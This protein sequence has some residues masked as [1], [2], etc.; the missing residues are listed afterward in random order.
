MLRA[1]TICFF[2]STHFSLTSLPPVISSTI[3]S[4]HSC[5]IWSPHNCHSDIQPPSHRS[6]LHSPVI[7]SPASL[8]ITKSSTCLPLP[9]LYHCLS[10][11]MISY[12]FPLTH[13]HSCVRA[14]SILPS[15]TGTQFFIPIAHFL[16]AIL[17]ATIHCSSIP[18]H[19]H[20]SLCHSIF[21]VPVT[22]VLPATVTLSSPTP[23][24]SLFPA[25]L[26]TTQ[27]SMA[28]VLHFPWNAKSLQ[29]P[30]PLPSL[31]R[32]PLDHSLSLNPPSIPS[33][34]V[35][36]SVPALPVSHFPS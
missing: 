10:F 34:D 33:S 27:S 7:H 9:P 1:L 14:P 15:P 20:L 31:H 22:R 13:H 26:W 2:I 28:L 18:P 25:H 35:N 30:C 4:S 17:S 32:L 23:S 5:F 6:A 36:C 3:S 12:S 21:Q 8:C 19:P 24:H 29:P 16:D 11:P